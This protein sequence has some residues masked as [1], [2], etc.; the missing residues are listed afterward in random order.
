MVGHD[1]QAVIRERAFPSA[2]LIG[3]PSDGFFGRT[4]AFTF[5]NFAAEVAIEESTAVNIRPARRDNGKFATIAEL[6]ADVT[7]HGYSPAQSLVTAAVKSFAEHCEGQGVRLDGRGFSI[8]YESTVP[9]H[10]GF[11]G[12]SALVTA[13]LRA[14][15]RHFRLDIERPALA[16]L[17]RAV[18][19]NELEVPAGYQDRVA[20]AYDCPVFMDFDR[21]L[22]D[23]QGHGLY[24]PLVGCRL[25]PLYIAYRPVFAQRTQRTCQD[26]E[27]RF[28]QGDPVVLEAIDF[29]ADLTLTALDV[30]FERDP[31]PLGP[32]LDANFDR[33]LEICPVT[34]ANLAAVKL[35]RSLGASAKLTGSGGALVGGYE[36]EEMLRALGI[37]FA[38]LGMLVIRPDIRGVT[39]DVRKTACGF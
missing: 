39:R 13:C 11:G 16:T 24:E 12:S 7:E 38:K 37:E 36:G 17:V 21:G 10:V 33:R 20:Q 19:R 3:N 25:P 34:Q 5:A 29:W 22:M 9:T 23:V 26:L 32:L 27:M 35:A 1:V 14:L 6:V 15:F 30:L 31:A 28:R 2:A 8:T 4:V 18:E